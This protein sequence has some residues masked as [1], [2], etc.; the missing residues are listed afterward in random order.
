MNS[1]VICVWPFVL[2]NKTMQI[3][4]PLFDFVVLLGYRHPLLQYEYNTSSNHPLGYLI[5]L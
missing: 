1:T 5:V 2:A 4:L 3:V